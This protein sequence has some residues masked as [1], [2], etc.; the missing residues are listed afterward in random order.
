M[1]RAGQARLRDFDS[2]ALDALSVHHRPGQVRELRN[3][4]H[5][6]HVLADG[7]VITA[8]LVRAVLDGVRPSAPVVP[9]GAAFVEARIGDSPDQVERRVLEQTLAFVSG[10]KQCAAEILQVRVKTIHDTPSATGSRTDAR[11]TVRRTGPL[12]IAQDVCLIASWIS[13]SAELCSRWRGL[14]SW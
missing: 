12:S 4:R 2:E 6:A 8:D 7:P 5:R 13:R 9:T 10:H 1:E 3:A 14:S 11:R